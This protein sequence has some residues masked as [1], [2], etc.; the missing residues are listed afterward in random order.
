MMLFGNALVTELLRNKKL[1]RIVSVASLGIEA[2][3][4]G[5]LDRGRGTEWKFM[6]HVIFGHFLPKIGIAHV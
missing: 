3:G 5:P 6:C 2:L 1:L 4:E